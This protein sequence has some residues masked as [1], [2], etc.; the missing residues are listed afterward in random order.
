MWQTN[1]SFSI[2][3][4]GCT[5]VKICVHPGKIDMEPNNVGF[6]DDFP[7]QLGDF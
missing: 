1:I 5:L 7:F 2:D 4:D 3:G 6:E